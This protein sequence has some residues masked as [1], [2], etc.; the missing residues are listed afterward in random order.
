[1][2]LLSG[3]L[4]VQHT[5]PGA[6]LRDLLPALVV[7]LVALPLSLGVAM[8]SGVPPAAGLISAI[9][10]G[11]VVGRLAGS[12]LQ[13]SGPAAGLAVLVFDLV[14]TWGLATLGVIVVLA[15]AMQALAGA[16][17]L[18]RWFRAVS[19][20]L[21]QGMLAGIGLVIL[22]SQLLVLFDASPTGTSLGDWLAIPAAALGALDGGTALA[23]AAVG[24]VAIGSIVGWE[25]WRPARLEAVP[26][27]LIGVA[28]ASALALAS[29]LPVPY[30]QLPSDLIATIDFTT[31]SELLAGLASPGI[32]AA[33]AG[34]AA[35][36]SAEAMLS[37][38][39]VDQLHEHERTDYDREL[40][41]QGVGNLFAGALGALPVTGVIVRSSANV[42]AG[43]SSRLPAMLHGLALLVLVLGAPTLLQAIPLA[44]LAAVLVVTGVRLLGVGK[45]VQLWRFDRGEAVVFAT[46]A[47]AI[48]GTDLLTG[49]IVGFALAGARLLWRTTHLELHVHRDDVTR[50]V[51][52]Q[53]VGSATFVNVP[54]L[55][56]ALDAIPDGYSLSLDHGRLRHLDH[57][58]VSLLKGWEDSRRTR[59][60]TLDVEW[61][62]LM[63][64]YVTPGA[65]GAEAL[66]R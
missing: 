10:G 21:V 36:A 31:P 60:N 55:A 65:A 43:A 11:L 49:V 47:L 41:A 56:E 4:G 12:P 18:G 26:G 62:G 34:L 2:S 45:L 57:A 51:S 29:G 53:L 35:V 38:T 16:F 5:T 19:P 20:A 37:A 48:V 25:Q 30:V 15:G 52:L 1:M 54:D 9:V 66:A 39:A 63:E 23:S 33:A 46:T 13:V 17:K 3:A 40:L 22:A 59:G 61:S 14:H 50:S 8:A 42:Q 28:G 27:A 6:Y 44:A 64:R 32:W 24:L 58:A 7:F